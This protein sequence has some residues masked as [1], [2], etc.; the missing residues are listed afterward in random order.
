MPA[1]DKL[2]VL[3]I[4]TFFSGLLLVLFSL[5]LT[6]FLFLDNFSHQLLISALILP[7]QLK[8]LFLISQIVVDKCILD[9]GNQ[10]KFTTVLALLY[11]FFQHC[12]LLVLLSNLFYFH[13]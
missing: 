8:Q 11:L 7:K 12:D 2:V 1:L 3:V 5:N 10:F 9:L 4:I 6:Y 13:I